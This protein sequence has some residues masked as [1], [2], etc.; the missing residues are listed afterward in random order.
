MGING[1]GRKSAVEKYDNPMDYL[2]GHV[3]PVED[4][5]ELCKKDLAEAQRKFKAAVARTNLQQQ[6]L[7]WAYKGLSKWRK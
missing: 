5:L 7:D 2:K 3:Y 1:L 6:K 4:G